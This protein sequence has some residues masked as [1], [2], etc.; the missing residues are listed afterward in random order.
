MSAATSPE[1][2]FRIQLK[3]YVDLLFIFTRYQRRD[4]SPYRYVF[5]HDMLISKYSR[6]LGKHKAVEQLVILA[7]C[8]HWISIQVDTTASIPNC[9]GLLPYARTGMVIGEKDNRILIYYLCACIAESNDRY[10]LRDNSFF[11]SFAHC[12]ITADRCPVE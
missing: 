6:I 9:F 4:S 3:S 5:L 2:F 10:S 1:Y 12:G 11:P 8:P 7:G